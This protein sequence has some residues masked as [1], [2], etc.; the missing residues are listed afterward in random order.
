[1]APGGW[2]VEKWNR[3]KKE[4]DSIQ[5]IQVAGLAR[6]MVDHVSGPVQDAF[7]PGEGRDREKHLDAISDIAENELD[8]VLAPPPLG[9][10]K[11]SRSDP[12]PLRPDQICVGKWAA[13]TGELKT[14]SE[15]NPWHVRACGA[16][17]G[18]THEEGVKRQPTRPAREDAV[19]LSPCY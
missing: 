6:S 5:H 15:T 4:V 1:M 10:P 8:R 18:N 9:T 7:A 3:N 12:M 14:P 11:P 17:P 16:R 13:D 19:V 2:Y